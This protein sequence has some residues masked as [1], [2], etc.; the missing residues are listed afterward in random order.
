MLDRF[1]VP[2]EDRV[3][4]EES[5]VRAATEAIFRALGMEDHDA[6]RCADVLISND[7]RGVETH[8]VSNMLRSYIANYRAGDLDPRGGA[9]RHRA[10]VRDHHRVQPR[11]AGDGDEELAR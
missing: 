7:L 5:A 1:K 8:G 3:Y 10:E 6:W 9:L 4:V 2:E 11:P